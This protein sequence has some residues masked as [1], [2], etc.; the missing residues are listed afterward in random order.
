MEELGAL[1]QLIVPIMGINLVFNLEVILYTWIVI[2][3]LLVLGFIAA[4]VPGTLQVLGE[5]LMTH[6]Y[7]LTEDSIGKMLTITYI[8]EQAKP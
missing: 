4:R 3:L 8:G 1:H 2:L 5:L 6:L 7:K